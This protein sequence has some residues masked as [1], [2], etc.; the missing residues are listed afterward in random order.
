MYLGSSGATSL[1]A[2]NGARGAGSLASREGPV[3]RGALMSAA[4]SGMG[5]GEVSGGS[6]RS[7]RV[8]AGRGATAAVGLARRLRQQSEEADAKRRFT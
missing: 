5:R 6:S 2:N 4:T 7:T 3:C 8:G 1:S